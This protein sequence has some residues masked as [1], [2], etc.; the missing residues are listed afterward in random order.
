MSAFFLIYLQQL[1]FHL[2][3]L[4]H[5]G[6][7]MW[8]SLKLKLEDRFLSQLSIQG[9][10]QRFLLVI[11]SRKNFT[12]L[13]LCSQQCTPFVSFLLLVSAA[14]T[15]TIASSRI[16]ST[17][18]DSVNWSTWTIYCTAYQRRFSTQKFIPFSFAVSRITPIT[19]TTTTKTT[20]ITL[21]IY[22]SHRHCYSPQC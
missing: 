18:I 17:K 9:I 2:P 14:V 22:Y 1:H 5:M 16:W 3:H 21:L 6:F 19:T 10:L 12:S 11:S 7:S 4:L 20:L 15:T 13:Y 8:F